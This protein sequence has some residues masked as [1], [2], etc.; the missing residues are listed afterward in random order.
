MNTNDTMIYLD[1]SATTAP[2]EGVIAAMTDAARCYGNP[3]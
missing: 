2:S 3:S 1:N